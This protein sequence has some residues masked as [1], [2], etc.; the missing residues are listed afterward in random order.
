M[1]DNER[2]GFLYIEGLG[3]G[4]KYIHLGFGVIVSEDALKVSILNAI[5]EM[6][7]EW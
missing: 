7:E 2:S 3:E 5:R 4:T 6:K 1:R